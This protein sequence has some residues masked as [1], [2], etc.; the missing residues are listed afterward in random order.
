[1]NKAGYRL[2]YRASSDRR[3][4][5]YRS[6]SHFKLNTRRLGSI[7]QSGKLFYNEKKKDG[8]VLTLMMVLMK[9]NNYEP[10]LSSTTYNKLYEE[11][12]NFTASIGYNKANE[13]LIIQRA[14][15]FYNARS[16]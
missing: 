13:E 5:D 11:E 2:H 16:K 10:F 1:M 3:P 9:V 15:E 12:F 7:T 4:F 6:Y 8:D 14:T